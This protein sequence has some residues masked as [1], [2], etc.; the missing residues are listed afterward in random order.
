MNIIDH[1]NPD[2]EEMKNYFMIL[3]K[4][5][6]QDDLG[7]PYSSAD[8]PCAYD[9]SP[10]PNPSFVKHSEDINV[11]KKYINIIKLHLYLTGEF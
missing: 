2:L 10:C 8:M 5:P 7:A 11:I 1:F 4:H 3:T 9:W 6:Y